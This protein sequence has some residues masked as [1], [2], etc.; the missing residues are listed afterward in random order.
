MFFFYLC[1]LFTILPSSFTVFW[2]W[3]FFN[4]C[5]NSSTCSTY[6]HFLVPKWIN[7]IFDISWHFS[8]FAAKAAG[9]ESFTVAA[10][11]AQLDQMV[12]S[13]AVSVT[14]VDS[15]FISFAF[16]VFILQS[17]NSNCSILQHCSGRVPG[18]TVEGNDI[19]ICHA[20]ML[21]ASL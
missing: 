5:L 12:R 19:E 3:D 10:G 17:F 18:G 13:G 4:L 21:C 16:N 20:V 15:G 6:L 8:C 2:A 9:L 11:M 14:E 1:S 7:G